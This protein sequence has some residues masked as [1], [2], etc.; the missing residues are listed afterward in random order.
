MPWMQNRS[1][2]VWLAV[3]LWHLSQASPHQPCLVLFLV[4]TVWGLMMGRKDLGFGPSLALLEGNPSDDPAP[5]G[6]LHS[7][8]TSLEGGTSEERETH[9]SNFNFEVGEMVAGFFLELLLILPAPS[10]PQISS[11]TF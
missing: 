9:T 6:L 7:S 1:E 11:Q 2:D 4:A 8:P 3:S 5:S 10:S